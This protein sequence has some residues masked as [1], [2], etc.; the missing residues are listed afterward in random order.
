MA[1]SSGNLYAWAFAADTETE[2]ALRAGLAGHEVRIRR[3]RLEAALRTLAAE[4]GS[5]LVFVDLDGHAQPEAAVRELTEVC[6]FGTAL[7]AMGS[8]DRADFVRAL[9]R[10]GIAD[11]LVKPISPALVR[12]ASTVATDGPP[13]RPYAGR[14]I[15][16]TGTSGSGISTLVATMALG[17]ATDKHT[18]SV[19]DLD[20]LS[21]KLPTLFDAVP[22]RDLS[23]LLDSFES[24]EA[25]NA[26]TTIDRD[27]VDIGIPV[28][29]GL[30]LIAYPLSGPMP[31]SPSPAAACALVEQLANRTHLVSVTGISDPDAQLE[32]MRRADARVLLFEP[33][34][35]SVSATVRRMALLGAEHPVILVQCQPRTRNGNMSRAH[36]RYAFADRHPDIVVPF[37]PALR[38]F[39]TGKAPPRPGRAYSKALRKMIERVVET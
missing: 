7:V 33:T 21:G 19:V 27:R 23:A 34:L 24:N 6:S 31:P 4:P 25:D 20:P 16:F 13:K 32:I 5:P 17:V 22:T 26:A 30:S 8:T 29:P 37:D 28:A 3:G 38:T 15:A 18:V 36:V 11:Y 35:T 14:V 2:R 9:L 39:S 1:S 12:E 10:L